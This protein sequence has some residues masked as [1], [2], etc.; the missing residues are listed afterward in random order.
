MKKVSVWHSAPKTEAAPVK[1]S[2]LFQD[3]NA[4]YQGGRVFSAFPTG[5]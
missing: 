2:G 5:Y 4:E 1:K 3:F